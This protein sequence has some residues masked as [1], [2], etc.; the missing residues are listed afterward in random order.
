MFI[1]TINVKTGH[2]TTK[3]FGLYSEFISMHELYFGEP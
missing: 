1:L 3:S 2:V